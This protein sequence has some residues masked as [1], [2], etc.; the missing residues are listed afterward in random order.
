MTVRAIN[1]NARQ[2]QAAWFGGDAPERE[3]LFNAVWKDLKRQF[4]DGDRRGK[5]GVKQMQADEG[6]MQWFYQPSR[7]KHD[8]SSE[9]AYMSYRRRMDKEMY[10][11]FAKALPKILKGNGYKGRYNFV[12]PYPGEHFVLTLK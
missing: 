10:P 11:E 7:T 4:G 1:M 6:E 3:A 5:S 8:F 12:E 2:L 9:G